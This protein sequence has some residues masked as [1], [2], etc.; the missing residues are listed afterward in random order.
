MC[1]G[2]CEASG[3]ARSTGRAWAKQG[4]AGHVP[5]LAARVRAACFGAVNAAKRER[6]DVLLPKGSQH[7]SR[8]DGR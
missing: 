1:S 2:A 6:L 3:T 5:R 8:M 4:R 7:E